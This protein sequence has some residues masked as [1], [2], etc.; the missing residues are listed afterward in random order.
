[1]AMYVGTGA[2]LREQYDISYLEESEHYVIEAIGSGVR[3]IPL[4][5][6]STHYDYFAAFRTPFSS[7]KIRRVIEKTVKLLGV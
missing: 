1:M 6:F 5:Q 4:A 2:W 3:M 7:E